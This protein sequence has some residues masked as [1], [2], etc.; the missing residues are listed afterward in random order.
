MPILSLSATRDSVFTRIYDYFKVVVEQVIV[1]N[2]TDDKSSKNTLFEELKHVKQ[3]DHQRD[4]YAAKSNDVADTSELFPSQN[5]EQLSLTSK[6]SVVPCALNLDNLQT[7][8]SIETDKNGIVRTRLNLGEAIS[9]DSAID[10]P[11]KS[12]NDL[13]SSPLLHES[14]INTDQYKALFP[15]NFLPITPISSVITPASKKCIDE[16][17]LSDEI[18]GTAD[19][20][21]EASFIIHMPLL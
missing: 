9:R 18:Q 20:S 21:S 6:S 1:P 4:S 10:E 3:D 14:Y 11:T 19:E 17:P 12:Q 13:L 15:S 8:F 5:N 7:A 2:A 16:S